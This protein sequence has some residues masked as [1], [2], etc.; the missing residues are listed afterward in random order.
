MAHGQAAWRGWVHGAL[1]L[2]MLL[3]QQGS[4]QH[5][6]SHWASGQGHVH[7]SAPE[8]RHS[9]ETSEAPCLQCLAY[10]AMADSLQDAAPAGLLS[11]LAHVCTTPLA[12]T[13]LEAST[14]LA[15]R[16]RAPPQA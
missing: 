8:Q 13:P 12:H 10:A 5:G 7:V 11:S 1:V 14:T 6:L 16:S 2:L 4:W 9:L 15:Y 3:A